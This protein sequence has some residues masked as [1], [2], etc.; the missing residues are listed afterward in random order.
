MFYDAYLNFARMK[1]FWPD[2]ELEQAK[3][4]VL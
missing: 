2:I 4:E 3:E 1:R